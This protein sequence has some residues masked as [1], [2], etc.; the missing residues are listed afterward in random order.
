MCQP[1]TSLKDNMDNATQA[2]LLS[3]L[4]LLIAT[5]GYQY[6]STPPAG[7]LMINDRKMSQPNGGQNGHVHWEEMNGDDGSNIARM[8]GE[9]LL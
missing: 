8:F 5:A 9:A 7:R 4:L 1:P 3:A 2:S 6:S